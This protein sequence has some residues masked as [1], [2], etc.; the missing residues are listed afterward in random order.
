MV[1][2]NGSTSVWYSIHPKSEIYVRQNPG[3]GEYSS[4]AAAIAA[5]PT[6]GPNVP[7]ATNQ[8]A[9]KV[10]AGTYT[11][12]AITIPTWV[13]VVGEEMEAVTF[14]PAAMG[15]IFFTFQTNSGLNFCGISNTDPA[16]PACYF[17]NCGNFCLMHKV[18]FTSCPM[19]V[20][21]VT[22]SSATQDSQ[23]F[24]EY[25]DMT[26]ST[27]YSLM[28]QDTN[29]PGGYGSDVSIENYFTFGHSNDA[30]IVTGQN[31]ILYSHATTLQGDGAGNCIHISHGGEVDI[32]AMA[33][34]AFQNGILVDPQVTT[35]I[36]A[37]SNGHVLPQS[38]INVAST[39]GFLTAGT[40]LIGGSSV[41]YTGVTSTSFTGCTGGSDT[42]TTGETVSEGSVPNVL[43]SAIT[44]TSCTNNINIQNVLTQGHSDGYTKYLKTLIPEQAPYFIANQ[45]QHIITVAYKGANFNVVDYG[46]GAIAAALAAITNNSATNRYTI[47]IGPG[48]FVEPQLQMK[49]YVSVVGSGSQNTIIMAMDPTKALIEG[50]YYSFLQKVTLTSANPMFP[51]GVYAPY[52]IEYLGD[53]TGNNFWVD[54]IIF[55]TAVGLV[56]V[57]SVNGPTIMLITNCLVNMEA[58]FTTGIT[59]SDAGPNTYPIS[60]I[61]DNLIWSADSVGL[62]N[63]TN[64]LTINSVATSSPV[65]YN[66][67]FVMTNSSIG[68]Y[69][70]QQ[71]I[72]VSITGLAFVTVETTILGGFVTGLIVNNSAQQTKLINSVCTYSTNTTDIN[73]ASSTAIGTVNA[74]A[75]ISKVLVNPSATVGI[76]LDDP[77]GAVAFGGDIY[78]GENWNHLTEISDQ[79]QHACVTGKIDGQ[80]ILADVGGLN[81][82]VSGGQGYV[83]IG[84]ID[85]NYMQN[86]Y[87]NTLSSLTLSNNTLTYIYVDPTG[88]VNSSSSNPDPIGNIVLGSVYTYNGSITYIQQTGRVINNLAT[89]LDTTFRDVFGPIVQSGCIGYPG[90]NGTQLAVSVSSGAYWLSSISYPIGGGTN[91]TMIPFYNG[92]QQSPNITS[93]PLVWNDLGTSSLV[94]LTAGQWA[95]HALYII[96]Y[97]YGDVSFTGSISG[98]LLTV[99][100]VS[101]GTLKIGQVVWGSG[102]TQGTTIIAFGSGT[103]GTGTYTIS[104]SQTVG[105]ESLNVYSTQYML[106][107]G[108]Q[109]F[110]SE[111]SADVGPLPLP[112]A[113]FV[114]NVCQIS[115]IV[116]TYGDV[117]PLAPTRFRDVRPTLSYHSSGVTATADHNSLLNLTV[118]NAHPQYF[119]VD[120]TEPMQGNINLA[121]YDEYGSGYP[122]SFTGSISGTTLTVTA[123]S[124]GALALEQIV[125]GNGV[126][127]GTTITAFGTGTGGTGTYTITPSQTVG[128]ESMTS[129]G[130]NLF[131][132]V[133][134]TFHNQRHLPGGQ[135]ALATGVPVSIDSANQEGVAAA[136]ARAD[137]VHQGVASLTGTTNEVSVSG[138]IGS[139]TISTPT[140]FIAPGTIQDTT[141][142]AYSAT[143]GIVANGATQGTA[144]PITTSFNSV[145]SVAAGTG[146]VLPSISI[147]GYRCVIANQDTNTLLVYP[148]LGAS[149]DGLSTNTPASIPANA[150]STFE[151]DS[152]THWCTV[153]QNVIGGTGIS[154]SYSGASATVANTGVLGIKANGGTSETGTVNFVQGSNVTI[155]DSPAGT[156]TISVSAGAGGVSSIKANGGTAEVGAVTLS[157]GTGISITDSPAGTFNFTN[158]GV[159]SVSGTSNQIA[160]SGSTGAVTFSLPSSV[161]TGSLTLTGLTANSFLYSGTGGLLT[162]T[163]APTNGQ[164]LIGSTGL[165]PVAAALTAGTGISVTNGAGSISIANTGVTSF[166]TSLN[167]LSPSSSSTGAIT[168]AGTLG[169]TSGGTGSTTAP[170]SGQLPVGTSG[171][172]Y[173]P[174]TVTTGTGISTTTGSGTFQINNTGV[175]SNVAGTGISVS[176]ATGAVTISNTGVTSATGTANQ[177]TVSGSTGAVTFSLPSSVSTGSLTLTGLTAQ[178]FLYSG[179]GGLLT[180]TAAP[181]NGQILI[182]NTGTSP[183]VSTLTAGTGITI[184]NGAGTITIAAN[185]AALVTSFSAGTTGFTP[186]TATTG[187]ITLAGTLNIA[188]G[189]T[190]LTTTPTNGQLLIGNGT[191][192]TLAALAGTA[193]QITVTNG[194]G[195]ITLSIPAAFTAPG[196]VTTTTTLITGTLYSDGTTTGITAAGTTQGTGTALTKSYNIVT[197]TPSGTGVVL[198]TATVGMKVRIV[199]KGANALNVYPASGGT[200]D[201]AAANA[202]V[203][204]PVGTTATYQASSGTQW[205]SVVPALVVGSG[206][207]VTYGNGQTTF[208]NTGVTSLTGTLHQINVSASTGAVTLST[209]Q[210]IDT[211]STPTFASLNLSNTANQLVLGTS[212]TLTINASAPSASRTYTISDPGANANFVMDTAGALAITNTA[213]T[214]YALVATG[215]TT[216]TWQ[217]TSSIGVTSFSAGTTG[218]SPSTA[219]TGAITLSGTL[220]VA[221]GGTGLSTT[222]TAGQI[223]IGNGTSYTLTTI[224]GTANQITVT[225]GTGSITLSIPTTLTAP[226]S[227]SS[228]TTL[229]VGTLYSDGTTT[230]IT[231]SGTTQGTAT[232][233]STSYNIVTT[234]PSG[235]GVILPTATTGMKVI[236][237]NKGA[238]T[239]NVYPGTGAAIDGASTN[240]AVTIPTGTSVTYEAS[241]STQWYSIMPALVTGTGIS[242]TYGNGQTTFSNTGVTS[243]TGTLHQINVSAS[244]GAVT[245]STPQNIDTTSTPTFA[246]L[247]LSNTTNQIVLGTTN[248]TTISSTAPSASRTYT[249]ADPGGNANFVMDTGGALTITNSATT[250]YALLATGTNTATWQSVSSFGVTSFSA[251]TT[252]FSP[253]TATSG[254]ITLTGTLNVSNGG[255]GLST[256]PTNGQILI[257]N[258][259]G[260]TLSTLTGTANQ[261]TVTNGSGSVTLSLPSA[262]TISSS[263]T[264]SGLTAN[265]FLYSGTAGLLTTTAA[266]TNG[267]ILIGSTG[268]APVAATITPGTAISVVSGAGSITVNNTGVTSVAGT[269]HQISVSSG[270]G[271]V[272]ISTPQNIDTTSTPTFANLTLTNTTNQL[273]LGTTNTVTLSATAPGTSR[274][275]TIPDP[276]AN[277]NFV[278]DTGGALTITNTGTTGYALVAT[279][280]NTATWQTFSSGAVT[281]FSGGTTGLTPNTPTSGAVTLGGILVVANGGTGLSTSPTNGQ[282]LIGNG[283]GYTLG[284]LTGTANEITVT[285]ASGSIT[286]SVPSSFVAP[287]SVTSTTS[288]TSGTTLSVGTLYSDGTT[289]GITAAGTTQGTG[290]ALT[291]SYN[292]VTTTPSGTG[293]VLP[294]ATTGMKVI[295]VNKGVNTLNVYPASSA[296]IDGAATNAAVTIPSGTTATYEA[297]SSTQW[298]SVSPVILGGTA[299]S[300]S[301][302]NGQTIMSNTGVTSLTGT[303]HQINVS[304]S[305]G[306]I[307]LSTPQNIDTTSTPTFANLTLTNTTNQLVLGTTNTTTISASAPSA[308]RTYT[309][310][311]PGANANFVMDTAGALTITNTGTT[312]YALVSTGT[313]TATWQAF[314][315]EAVTTFS[316]GTTGFTP[317]TATSGAVTLAGTLN[318]ANGGTGLTTSPTNGQLLI[319]NGTGYTLSTLTG[320]ANQITVTNG[321]GSVTLSVPT[322]FTGPGSI[323]ATTS[324]SA[325]TSVSSTTSMSAG[326]TLTVGTLYS[327]GTTT[328]ISAAGSSQGTA[329]ALTTSYNIVSTVG[330]GQGVVLPTATA[331]MKVIIVNKGANA[332]SVYPA[333][334]AAIDSAGTNA[335]VILP[336]G[337]SATYQAS[338]TTQWYSI[339][340]AFVS[341]TGISISYGNGQVTV[342]NSGVTQISGT[343]NQIIA[344]ASTGSITLSTPQNIATTSTPTFANLTLSNTTNQLV[345]GTTNTA[346]ISATAPSASRTYTISDPGANAN[347]VMDT[348]S[349]LTITNVATSGYALV[350]TGTNTATWQTFSSS[351]VTS[352]TGTANQILVNGTS[353]SAQ[354]GAIT[355]TLPSSVTITTAL[356]ISGLTANSFLY[357]GT[358]GLLT[359]TT[360]PTNGQILIGSTGAAP[361]AA[362]ISTSG[363]GISVTNG[364]GTI[365]LANTGVTSNVAGTGISVSGATGAVT[366]SNTGVTSITGTANQITASAS[367]GAVT[368]SLPSS[369]STGSLTLTGLTANSFLYSGTAGLLTTT[370]A[371]T[372][373][374]ILIGSTGAAP[375]STTLTAGSGI[376]IT[377]GAGSVTI[378]ANASGVV[379]SFSAGTTGFTPST[380][381]TGAITLAGTLNVANGGTGLSTSPTNGQLLIG[382]GTGYTL[383]ALAGTANQI[384]VTNAS[385]SITLSLPSAVTISSSL[386]VSG[387]IAN[388]FLYSGT[389]G[390]LTTTTAPTNGQILIGSTGA[391][392]VSATIS[393]SGSGISVTNGAGT[394]TLANTGVTSNVAGTGISVSGATGAVTIS[395]T[396]V[397]SLAGTANQITASASTGAITLSTPATFVA[398]GTIQDTTG[399]KYSTTGSISAA[400][401]TQGTGTALTTSYNIVT[402]VASGTGVVLPAGSAGLRVVVVNKGANSLNVYPASGAAI[403]S[404]ATNAAVVL[405]VNGTATYEAL[406]ATQWYTV[407]P[408]TVA[409]T[410]TTITFGNGQTTITNSGVTSLTAGTGISVS[411]GTGAITIGNTGVTSAVAGTGISVSGAT[412]A[413]TFTNTGVTSLTGTANQITVSA[414]TGA[415]TL[416]TPQ[417]IATTSTPTF[418]NLTLTNTTN[419]LVLGTTNTATISA[420]APSASR[421][422]TIPDPGA[423]ANFVMDTAGALTI[424]NTATT[425]YSLVA[426]G[427]NTA[428]WQAAASSGVSSATGTANQILVNGTSGSAQTG[429]ITLTLPSSVTITT[430]LTIS[431]LTANSFLYSGTAGALTTTSAP[432]NGQLLIGSTGAAP[433]AAALTAG[434]GITVTNGAG[435]ITIASNR[436]SIPQIITACTSQFSIGNG[437]TVNL[438]YIPWQNSRLG[439]YSNRLVTVWAVPSSN[440]ANTLSINVYPNG[441]GS[442]GNVSIPGGSAVGAIYTFTIT[443]PGADTSLQFIGTRTGAG[444][445]NPIVFG[446]TLEVY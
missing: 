147:I 19:A 36:S 340:P 135:D 119:R 61:C 310:P 423:N 190:G 399:M 327:D 293:V 110:A 388:S 317:N 338:T 425:G 131:N 203:V 263:L 283:T 103:G 220:N 28:C 384:T 356:T 229:S 292:I 363:S 87:W 379:T 244:T 217:S 275:Y 302:G 260:Y 258:G 215:S 271:N 207:S 104:I 204:L 266:P 174:F 53:P 400:G 136:F 67:F 21:C 193:N 278:M 78:Q 14:I 368:L 69:F 184:T 298:Y 314:T 295:V 165:A 20:S 195:T 364:T 397:T 142:I 216:A 39:T 357:S 386:T 40:I 279:G 334:G 85:D 133:D 186:N 183:T 445:N 160:V 380:A 335:S 148:A 416:S 22:D 169:A 406:S 269:A 16:Y 200:I 376:T 289:T 409:G 34:Y 238:N 48:I 77:S 344:S 59:V 127:Q 350:A 35:T 442:L 326:T 109:T 280:A 237:V 325:G 253:S 359:T 414:S 286:L 381:T 435:S 351:S 324:L 436:L 145:S 339:E 32:Q 199:N 211:T 245:L 156:F 58:Q 95:V 387:L 12:P 284:T 102:V 98:T 167:G 172:T 241:S 307:T 254:A 408:V 316:A 66:I 430:G 309:I 389:A 224:S 328:G 352:A 113:T 198:P 294:T 96:G 396:G 64:F 347:F 4:L 402:T 149:I 46:T 6:S 90:N 360:A 259:T 434:T 321:S 57:G 274:T 153:V 23:L 252:G 249:I 247:T 99:S 185:S 231:A 383:A 218:F 137:H 157:N 311:D 242:A 362:T 30:I 277:A 222:P 31:T 361:V 232:A 70:T 424:T 257:G 411:S 367:T 144:T 132:N 63:F 377:N 86:V 51:I 5:V 265:S 180:S 299:I 330:L 122:C 438:G 296:A 373:G 431:G 81:I 60:G 348:A 206:L 433:V 129:F 226:G 420:S 236:V 429:A 50:A 417:N 192:Y 191:G 282:L 210:N 349:S 188:N 354:T 264:V 288:I 427:T 268:A 120:G 107:Y 13:Y 374:Q 441:G 228:T 123:V 331:G 421:T 182:G 92:T 255:T 176:G 179:P 9:I 227:I 390:L 54:N 407:N 329:T 439:G 208:A 221:N 45:D 138:S 108:Q 375:V 240:T 43:T 100:A 267:Q 7:S 412:G 285:N 398:P 300:V 163:A 320:T 304:A 162:S 287:G 235:T 432:T 415:I 405:P 419:Q 337:V 345:L 322:T 239:L 117:G 355:L 196:S 440:A 143:T 301:Y 139:I 291:T 26:S 233:I 444:G 166:Q 89:N 323:T 366:I 333:T 155:T 385:G 116:V 171:G 49:N 18:T 378:S 111:A 11:E 443:N 312:G 212:N 401:T 437:A 230:G 106:V 65:I 10:F 276:G 105:S 189:G 358:A 194:A 146:V 134:P 272:T 446:I 290:T 3:P 25:V 248:T 173:T 115:G 177:I 313:N 83:F 422:Y 1:T 426:T 341:G 213:T 281:T 118:G 47:Q 343:A 178:S 410:G 336:A 2:T 140:T 394:I 219:T 428:T 214:G 62:T 305:T 125:S 158:T 297:S 68:Q 154:V 150:S 332:L 44:Y 141:G 246:N 413:V 201:G 181:T 243:L 391:A 371:P 33:I 76:I 306:A 161:S 52:L 319:G 159:T 262:V 365:T 392:P 202:A 251:G 353:G 261:I 37:A 38:T 270:T 395:N 403:D 205:Y 303:L 80:A 24:L 342:S 121:T 273:V 112:P 93:V 101:S 114:G 8:W 75:S 88:T 74:T 41:T 175:T 72:G 71:G 308:S 124:T 168:L 42:L 315:A 151:S 393:T 318:V 27:V 152:L 82:S 369:V 346:T 370:T 15:Y 372:N 84:P 97:L 250:G 234:T 225:N 91:V 382:N 128:S 187:A 256:S 164:L 73:I 130:G 209:P 126:I 56:N 94:A 170:T 79:I 404:A 29:G 55:D 17:Y 418:A 223:L 197:T